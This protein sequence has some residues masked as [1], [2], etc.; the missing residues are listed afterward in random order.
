MSEFRYDSIDDFQYPTNDSHLLSITLSTKSTPADNNEMSDDLNVP[1]MVFEILVAIFA[2]VGNF[3]V[4][5]VFRRD[6]KLRR[7]TNYYIVSLAMA[8]FLVGSLGVPFAILASIGLP[9]DLYTCLFTVSLLVVLCTISIFCLV[10][11]SVDRYWAILYPMAYSRNVRTRTAII[12]ISLCWVAGTIVGF[13]PLFGWHVK[14]ENEADMTCHFVKVMDYNY[15]VFLYFATIITPALLMLAFYTHIYRVIVKQ[16]RQIVTMNPMS[17]S[18]RRNSNAQMQP[19]RNCHG[20]TMLRVLGA[21]RKRDV[22]ATQNLSIIVLFFMIC[23]FPLY[24]INCIKAFCPD[25]QVPGKLTLFCIILSHLNSA[26]NPVLYAYHLKDFRLALKNLLLKIMGIEVEQ[27]VDPMHRFSL[28]SQHR[29]HSIDASMRHSLQPRIYID[30]PIWLRQQQQTL[31]SSQLVPK[32]GVITPCLNNIHQTVAAVASVPTDIGRD[33]W[34]I[35]EASSGAELEDVNYEFPLDRSSNTPPTPVSQQ[36]RRDSSLEL[37]NTPDYS[38]NNCNYEVSPDESEL[39]EVFLPNMRNSSGS[40]SV[41]SVRPNGHLS[42]A[43]RSEMIA[44]AMREKLRSDDTDYQ[45]QVLSNQRALT[46]SSYSDYDVQKQSAGHTPPAKGRLLTTLRQQRLPQ[47]EL[48]GEHGN[49]GKAAA[50]N[51]GDAVEHSGIGL[52][53]RSTSSQSGL[54]NSG[55][56]VIENDTSPLSPRRK[57]K[58]KKAQRLTKNFNKTA[59]VVKNTNSRQAISCTSES[60]SATPSTELVNGGQTTDAPTNLQTNST[61]NGSIAQQQAADAGSSPLHN[62]NSNNNYN[63]T[64]NTHHKLNCHVAERHQQQPHTIHGHQQHD[65]FGPLRAV[66]HLL[67]PPL[68]KHS[69]LFHLFQP[70]VSSGDPAKVHNAAATSAP[71]T[72]ASA[73]AV[74]TTT[75]SAATVPNTTATTATTTT[76]ARHSERESS[77]MQ[78]A[79]RVASVDESILTTV[80]DLTDPT[81][82]PQSKAQPPPPTIDTRLG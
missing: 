54:S 60:S 16:V 48:V 68:A 77:Q 34:N 6:R 11:V 55:V 59:V 62:N 36:E 58:F 73:D 21:S 18:S 51:N 79:S 57:R 47:L 56:Y 15:L 64:N 8:D 17:D 53:S 20:G 10:A 30:S 72:K 69:S 13:L 31:K 41:D 32:C 24:T 80:T 25:C 66:G 46:D 37:C 38:Y 81:P 61:S 82:T 4:I 1:Y 3:M 42:N 23:W 50:A 12:I 52:C 74:Q 9:R 70:S 35:M 27:P 2:V 29:L 71:T 40:N 45:S 43:Q 63:R 44:G 19:G 5:V 67:F 33:M 22:K 39:D 7:R 76:A 75:T 26:G 14:P 28:A 78:I 65:M 49:R